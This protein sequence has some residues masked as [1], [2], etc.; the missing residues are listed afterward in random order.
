MEKDKFKLEPEWQDYLLR[1]PC[2]KCGEREGRIHWNQ[3]GQDIVYCKNNHH[4]YNAPKTETGRVPRTLS[5]VRN[6]SPSQRSRLLE[7]AHYRCELCGSQDS[8]TIAHILSVKDGFD[9]LTD[10]QLNS[11]ENTLVACAECNA[12]MGKRTPPVWLLVRMLWQRTK[13]PPSDQKPALQQFFAW[14]DQ[15]V[16]AKLSPEENER[17]RALVGQIVIEAKREVAEEHQRK[18][19]EAWKK[20]RAEEDKDYH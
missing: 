17:A 1:E 7:R 8:P 12:G 18:E 19:A 4:C 11:D 14:L 13:P 16:G 2:K 20:K 9:V 15:E 5:S 3:S 6:I 10:A